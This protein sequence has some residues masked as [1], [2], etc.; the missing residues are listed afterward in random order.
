[1]SKINEI[2]P[3]LPSKRP[4]SLLRQ[5]QQSS[6]HYAQDLIIVPGHRYTFT[7]TF[8]KPLIDRRKEMPWRETV[9][10][11]MKGD[12]EIIQNHQR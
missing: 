9:T 7:G 10:Y 1:M 4:D 8:P 5:L 12:L 6:E 11:V 2:Q 3:F